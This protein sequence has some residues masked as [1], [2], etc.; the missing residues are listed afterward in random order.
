MTERGGP[1]QQVTLSAQ[2]TRNG[3]AGVAFSPDGR[4]VM[5]G[6]TGIAATRVWDVTITGDAELANLP[7]VV[8]FQSDATYTPDGRH[9]VTTGPAGSV[10]VWDART[11]RRDRTLGP[12]AGPTPSPPWPGAGW[13]A[14][15]T[16]VEATQIEVSP[17]GGLVAVVSFSGQLQVWDAT[18]GE[19]AIA[20]DPAS[21]EWVAWVAWSP[22][23]D[24][25]A[26]AENSGDR[27]LVTIRDRTGREIAVV[28]EEPGASVASVAF[29]P[30]GGRLVTAGPSMEYG[31]PDGGEVVIWNWRDGEVERT[32]DAGADRAVL[33]PTGELIATVPH[34][35]SGPQ[36]EVWDWTTGQRVAALAR[37]TGFVVDLAFSADGSR[38]A[39]AS[40]DGTVRVW[41]PRSGEQLLLLR[42]HKGAVSSVAF[43]PDGSRLASAGADGTVRMWAL[44]LDDLVEIAENGLTRTL[45]DEECRQ[46]LHTERCP[47]P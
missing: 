16:G 39:T 10:N 23:G 30:D 12:P 8:F 28:R 33:S 15:D 4:Q 41:D 37:N 6:D 18:T 1:R 34:G 40:G 44:D 22:G 19:E 46:Y 31:E 32:I 3:V 42:G 2:D 45:T 43:S 7:A 11:F 26:A 47:R 25:L 14:T 20:T 36:V 38:L 35:Q 9:L 24:Y 21:S 27:G 17:D 13:L 5:T 29:S